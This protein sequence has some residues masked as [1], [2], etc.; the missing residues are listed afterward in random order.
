MIRRL[1]L[2]VALSAAL[3]A[4]ASA[5]PASPQDQFFANLHA[6]CGQSF[7]GRAVTTDSADAGLASERLVMQV[8]ECSDHEIRVPFHVGE[9]RSRTW[10]I[11]RTGAG[12]RLK[13]DHRHEDGTEDTLTQY[14]GDTTSEGTAERQEFPADAFSRELFTRNN[15]PAS[16]ANVWAVE[17]H[18]GR[19][20]AYE[21]QRPNRRLRVEFDLT[22]PIAAPPAPWGAD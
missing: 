6:L 13:H 8:R 20:F 19:T 12:L 14:G 10:V 22:A 1:L 11:T 9:N 7:A 21:L 5:P 16:V 3:S 2:A 4:C 15:T 17:I 18:P